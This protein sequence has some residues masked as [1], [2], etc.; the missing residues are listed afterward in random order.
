MKRPLD[1]VA[2]QPKKIRL[3][4]SKARTVIPERAELNKL[5]RSKLWTLCEASGVPKRRSRADCVKELLA[6]S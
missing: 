4:F 2:S 6:V 5:G 1:D 3:T